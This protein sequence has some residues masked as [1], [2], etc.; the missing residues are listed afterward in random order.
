MG[1]SASVG[2]HALLSALRQN[3]IFRIFRRPQFEP[4]SLPACT[5]ASDGFLLSNNQRGHLNGIARKFDF[6]N[7][8][9]FGQRFDSRSQ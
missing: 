2:E 3:R 5:T 8:L 7:V 9:V 6:S 1:L 4:Q